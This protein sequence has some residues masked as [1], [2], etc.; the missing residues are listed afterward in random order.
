MH[1]GEKLE[2]VLPLTVYLLSSVVYVRVHVYAWEDIGKKQSHQTEPLKGKR[3]EGGKLTHDK[4]HLSGHPA[5]G[6]KHRQG[7]HSVHLPARRYSDCQHPV[8]ICS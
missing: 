3:K 1:T 5:L 7:V 4:A 6:Y 8:D 2:I